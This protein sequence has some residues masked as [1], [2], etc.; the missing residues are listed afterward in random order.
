MPEFCII[1]FFRNGEFDGFDDFIGLKSRGE[2]ALEEIVG[3]DCAAIGPDCCVQRE[4]CGRIACRRIVVRER[5]ANC[6]TMANLAVADP[7]RES[8]DSWYPV[9]DGRMKCNGCVRR[10]RANGDAVG[11]D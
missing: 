11:L 10:H 7:G 9:A 3:A 4:Y 8:A 6:A 2:E 5:S 1:R